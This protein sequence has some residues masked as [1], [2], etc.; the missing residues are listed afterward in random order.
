M[1][2]GL[3]FLCAGVGVKDETAGTNAAT[4]TFFV[5]VPLQL[6]TTRGQQRLTVGTSI[7]RATVSMPVLE[8]STAAP[9]LLISTHVRS[10]QEHRKLPLSCQILTK[11]PKSIQNQPMPCDPNESFAIHAAT[12]PTSRPGQAS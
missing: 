9:P 10:W 7:M 2:C 11:T 8:A 4:K 6:R 1:V 5:A 12:T 3:W